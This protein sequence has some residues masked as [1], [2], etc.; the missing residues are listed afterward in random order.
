MYVYIYICHSHRYTGFYCLYSFVYMQYVYK[1][2]ILIYVLCIYVSID[3]AQGVF[4]VA[5]H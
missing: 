3:V 1:H 2:V 4:H 5:C